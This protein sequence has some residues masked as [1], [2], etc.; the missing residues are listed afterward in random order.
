[1]R[2]TNQMLART[3]QKSGIPLQQCTLL[4]IMNRESSGEDLLSSIGKTNKANAY[5]QRVSSKQ[6]KQLEASADALSCYAEK[7]CRTGEESLFGQAEKTGDT[8]GIV[9][10]IEDMADAYNKTLKYLKE[11]DSALNE[12]YL[13]ELQ[14]SVL[15]QTETLATV[16]ITC[17]KDGSLNIDKDSLKAAGIDDLKAVFQ[18]TSGFMEKIGYISGRVAENAKAAGES[19]LSGY[20][21]TGA[22]SIRSFTESM[23]D[24]WG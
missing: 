20:G 2:I 6:N 3:A 18:S 11:S 23:Y 12:F 7:I 4:D 13:Q 19:L 14:S 1:M 15:E 21:S 17:K 22:E 8:S 10:N 24:F 9:S 16:G 5:L